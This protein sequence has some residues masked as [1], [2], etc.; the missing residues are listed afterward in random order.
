MTTGNF[1][2]GGQAL[3]YDLANIKQVDSK[4][5]ASAFD[6]GNIIYDRTEQVFYKTNGTAWEPFGIAADVVES[7]AALRVLDGA[8]G[9]IVYLELANRRGFFYWDSSDLS[10]EVI[11]DPGQGIYISPL[12]D[13]TG[14]GGAWVRQYDGFVN[15]KWFGATGD[16]VTDDTTAF[17][18]AVSFVRDG[19]TLYIPKGTYR[20]NFEIDTAMSIIGDGYQSTLVPAVAGYVL[21]ITR[22]ADSAEQNRELHNPS[23]IV[24]GLRFYGND[25]GIAAGAVQ[26]QRIDKALFQDL[27]IEDFAQSAFNFVTSVRECAFVNVHTRWCGDKDAAGTDYPVWDVSDDLSQADAHNNLYWVNC[28]S[29]FPLG[30]NFY[31]DTVAGA[32]KVRNMKWTNCMMHGIVV[33]KDGNPYTFTADQ[34]TVRHLVIGTAEGEFASINTRWFVGGN[35]T[36]TIEMVSGSGDATLVLDGGSL[37]SEHYGT[38]TSASFPG[39]TVTSGSLV[40]GSVIYRGNDPSWSVGANGTYRQTL[41]TI[42][43]TGSDAS[44]DASAS[45]P[46]SIYHGGDLKMRGASIDQLAAV[47]TNAIEN[48]T[49][50]NVLIDVTGSGTN[51]TKWAVRSDNSGGSLTNRLL[52]HAVTLDNQEVRLAINTNLNLQDNDLLTDQT[53]TVSGT[54]GTVSSRFP[55]YD[56]SGSLLGYIPI[57]DSIT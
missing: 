10:T 3:S 47:Q 16:G 41:G 24:R 37:V 1:F 15:V 35:D 45:T 31:F 43:D 32:T 57:Y 14:A 23:L 5:A 18:N 8:V 44:V 2:N 52:L 7:L 40:N 38:N 55:I 6:S 17:E 9:D 27:I 13:A 48:Y 25:R 49:A 50:P 42:I 21:S 4:P 19:M 36:P 39:V 51:A 34:K 54:L 33:A 20:T 12:S 29:N 30:D 53:S 56:S 11:N 26:L 46:V 22:S 28:F